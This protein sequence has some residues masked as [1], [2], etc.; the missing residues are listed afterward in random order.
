MEHQKQYRERKKAAVDGVEEVRARNRQRYYERIARLKATGQ[1]EA[2]IKH[3]SRERVRHYHTM[4][5]ELREEVKRK[6]L[7][8]QKTWRERMIQGGPMK[9]IDNA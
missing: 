8:L 2:L 5:A 9:S 7:L 1:Y 4:L 3:K 6:N